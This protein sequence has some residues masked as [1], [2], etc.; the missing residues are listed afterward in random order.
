M[1]YQAI[2]IL[3]L[4]TPLNQQNNHIDLE[5]L[6]VELFMDPAEE[7]HS[8]LSENHNLLLIYNFQ[9]RS[10]QFSVTRLKF[11]KNKS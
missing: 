5:R 3:S 8:I 1:F 4:S 7:A 9:N 2:L 10:L 11:V 6:I